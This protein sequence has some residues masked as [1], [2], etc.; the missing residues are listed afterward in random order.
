V[1]ESNGTSWRH[2]LPVLTGPTV[3]LREPTPDDVGAIVDVLSVEDAAR[4]ALDGALND[5][6]IR[7]FVHRVRRDR[8]AGEA[9]TYVLSIAHSSRSVSGLV[10]VRALD[11]A[12]ETAEW[13]MTLAPSV[14][15]TGV[16]VETARLVG[17]FVFDRIGTYR[18]EARVP[19]HNGRAHGALQKIG[20]VQEGILRRS[21][22]RRGEY[23]DQ[24]LWAVLKDDWS[25]HLVLPAPRVH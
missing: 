11:P 4:F 20:A 13:E 9:F 6:R 25:D 8:A 5:L 24:V 10:Q 23:V 15:G 14:R 7:D 2:T 1:Q 18:L 19:V 3:I 16:F 12:F 17:S 22:R 21:G